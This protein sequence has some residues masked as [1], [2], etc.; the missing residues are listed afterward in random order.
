MKKKKAQALMRVALN[1]TQEQVA[2]IDRYLARHEPT[3]D[4]STWLRSVIMEAC[5]RSDIED[6][7][8]RG[9]PPE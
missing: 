3:I 7:I 6:T 2:A 9:R 1:M 4:R 5:G 8:R